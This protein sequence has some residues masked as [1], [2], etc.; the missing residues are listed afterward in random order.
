MLGRGCGPHLHPL[1]EWI[2]ALLQTLRIRA[3]SSLHDLST[4]EPT[5]TVRPAG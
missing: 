4:I 3:L 1:A 5:K 2:L